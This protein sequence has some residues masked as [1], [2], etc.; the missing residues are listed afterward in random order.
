MKPLAVDLYCGLGGWSDG[1]LADG[2]RCVG[3]DI[4]R[5]EYGEP[6]YPGELVLQD[7]LTLDGA[8]FKDAA[9]IVASPPCQAFSY[10]AFKGSKVPGFCFDRGGG[11]FQTAAVESVKNSGGSWF[12]VGSAGQKVTGNNPVHALAA[13][14]RK[15]RDHDGYQRSHP[16]A[17]GWRAPRTSSATTA[18]KMASAMIAKIPFPLA[19]HIARTFKPAAELVR[20]VA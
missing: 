14:G 7:V 6:R 16:D 9:L 12:N 11:S 8:Q 18:R 2:W 4:E 1:L 20:V 13:D 15:R 17:F 5:H 3:Y 19:L 10:M